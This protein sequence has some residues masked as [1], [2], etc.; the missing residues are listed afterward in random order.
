MMLSSHPA[1]EVVQAREA[2]LAWLGVSPC[3]CAS[4]EALAYA[5]VTRIRREFGLKLHAHWD[6]GAG[7]FKAHW[8]TLSGASAVE[9]PCPFRSEHL[10]HA[11]LLACSAT[12][13]VSAWLRERQPEAPRL[14]GRSRSLPGNYRTEIGSGPGS[15]SLS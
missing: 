6:D 12:L 11:R 8:T 4:D 9:L 10:D 5:A 2:V 13:E 14:R 3:E 7:H 1:T 15:T